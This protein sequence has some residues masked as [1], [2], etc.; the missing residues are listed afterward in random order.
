MKVHVVYEMARYLK[1]NGVNTVFVQMIDL[2]QKS[3]D[4][5][6]VVN[7][8]GR[9]DVF[10]AHSYGLIYFFRGLGYRGRRVLT[11]HVIPDSARGSIPGWQLMMPLIRWYFR[12]VYSYADICI[13]LSPMVEKA[14]LDLKSRTRIVRMYNPVPVD[15]W[16]SSPELRRLNR[17]HGI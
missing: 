14:I 10:H 16:K 8:Q 2:L 6:V 3:N 9:G 13:A 1:A 17:R 5:E 4:V 12:Q 15:F 7:G 11:V